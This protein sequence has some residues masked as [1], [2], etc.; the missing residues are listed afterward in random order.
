MR[1]DGLTI[2]HLKCSR[3]KTLVD[4]FRKR[5]DVGTDVVLEALKF[6]KSQGRQTVSFVDGTFW[7]PVIR[8]P[9][10]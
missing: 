7:G 4:C 6:Y 8:L 9:T 1:R 5:N 3:E 10:R 2:N